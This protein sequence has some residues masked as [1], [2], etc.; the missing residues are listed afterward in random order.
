MN[1]R[2]EYENRWWIKLY[3]LGVRGAIGLLLLL[4]VAAWADGVVTNYTEADLLAAMA[5]GGIVTFACDGTITLASTITN[6]IDTVIDGT[7]HQVT[8]SG[9]ARYAYS[10]L[11][12]PSTSRSST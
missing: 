2:G 3:K 5:G 6:S 11:V 1:A 10:T 8:I 9:V 4:P 12:L 7:G